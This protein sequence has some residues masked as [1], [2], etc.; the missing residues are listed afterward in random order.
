MRS[1]KWSTSALPLFVAGLAFLLGGCGLPGGVGQTQP[2]AA[3]T[4]TVPAVAKQA[5][6]LPAKRIGLDLIAVHDPSSSLYNGDCTGCHGER[7]NEVALDGTTPSAH[8]RMLFIHQ[9][10]GN[11]RCR[12][13]HKQPPDFLNYSAGG[14]RE[15]VNVEEKVTE[16]DSCTSC[17]ADQ[18]QKPLYV[19]GS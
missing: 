3:V 11:G 7:T 8:S 1:F 12:A 19:R 10:E 13:C 16:K 15:Q 14:L 4:Q 18:G 5:P 6:A 9:G 17:H 2:Q